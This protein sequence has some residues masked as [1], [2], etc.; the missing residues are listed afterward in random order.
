VIQGN[1]S[2]RHRFTAKMGSALCLRDQTWLTP[3]PLPRA[4]APGYS[5]RPIRDD[6]FRRVCLRKTIHLIRHGQSTF[7]AAYEATGIDPLHVDARLTAL[8]HA[9]VAAARDQVGGEA[10]ELIVTSPF[11]RA[12]ETTLGIFG[13]PQRPILVEALHRECLASS[14]DVGRSPTDLAGDFPGLSFAHLDDP[15]WH[16]GEERDALG[17]A[18]EPE[19][20]VAARLSAFRTWLAARPERHI[21][22]VGHGTFFFHLTGAR[23][24]NCEMLRWEL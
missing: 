14:C 10:Y 21:A 16:E 22:V 7:N 9:Q 23:L 5:S 12:I 17:I 19:P 15:W 18:V 8:G 20:V 4:G 11:T 13:G 2:Q 3:S 24:A 6:P 1:P